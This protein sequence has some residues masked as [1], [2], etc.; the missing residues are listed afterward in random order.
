MKKSKLIWRLFWILLIVGAAI[1]IDL[2]HTKGSYF[3]K[4]KKNIEL[5]RGLDLA[6]GVHL[7]YEVDLNKTDPK[8]KNNSVEGVKQTIDRR[9]NALGVTEPTIQEGKVGDKRTVIVE[10]PGIS[11]T[12]DA[13]NLIGKTAQLEFYEQSDDEGK[14]KNSPIP[15]FVPTGLTGANLKKAD[16]EMKNPN[17]VG[18]GRNAVVVSEPTVRIDFDGEGTKKF[19]E[20][21]KRNLQQPVAIVIDNQLISSPTVQS[22]ITDGTAIISGGFDIKSAKELAIALNSGALP[23]PINLIQEKT[24]GATLGK[25]SIQKS[26]LAGIIGIGLVM[27]FMIAYYGVKGIFASI[28]LSFYTLIVVAVFK[29]VPVTIT[30]SGIAGLILS[31][32]AAVDANILIFERMKEEQRT[33][34]NLQTSIDDG[35]RRAWSSIRDSNISSILTALI[36]LWFGSSLI[37]GF[38]LTLIIGILVSMFSAIT[39]SQTLL[40]LFYRQKIKTG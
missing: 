24:I 32:G 14:I 21:T 16:V 7:V 3:G 19:G 33:G 5:R 17:K 30:L 37:K 31:I 1:W 22:E 8:D 23:V 6:G 11:N 10:L 27:I 18:R 15:G 38:A 36:L 39:I 13:I 29:F 26:V 25:D 34:K 28:A 9:V 40:K 12:E 35:M 4:L 2:P 20:I